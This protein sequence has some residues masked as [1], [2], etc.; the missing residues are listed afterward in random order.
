M[1]KD[2]L[3]GGLD[4]EMLRNNLLIGLIVVVAGIVVAMVLV[5]SINTKEMLQDIITSSR[6][7]AQASS[8]L[9]TI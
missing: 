8:Q 2:D 1:N 5:R 6:A 3:I 4:V 7:L 9:A